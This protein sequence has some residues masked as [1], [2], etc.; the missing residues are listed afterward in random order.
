MVAQRMTPGIEG[1]TVHQADDPVFIPSVQALHSTA[2]NQDLVQRRLD[3]LHQASC[4][5]ASR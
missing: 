4:T 1:T 3:E 2:V 5:S